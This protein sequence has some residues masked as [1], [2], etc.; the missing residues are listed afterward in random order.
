MFLV[1]QK[2]EETKKQEKTK[3][4]EKKRKKRKKGREEGM[5]LGCRILQAR[6]SVL[7]NRFGFVLY[8]V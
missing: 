6:G 4:K 3:K 7:M 8:Q 1:E 2:Q 5:N